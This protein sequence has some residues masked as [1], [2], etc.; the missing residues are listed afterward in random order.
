MFIVLTKWNS[1]KKQYTQQKNP[2][3]LKEYTFNYKSEFCF[4]AAGFIFKG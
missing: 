1:G 2:K 4:K 3:Y